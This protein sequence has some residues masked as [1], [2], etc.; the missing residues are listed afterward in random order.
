MRRRRITAVSNLQA[1]NIALATGFVVTCGDAVQAISDKWHVPDSTVGFEHIAL[2]ALLVSIGAKV[3]FDDHAA[4]FRGKVQ[5]FLSVDTTFIVISY[6]LIISSA[7]VITLFTTATWLLAS[8]LAVLCAWNAAVLIIDLCGRKPPSPPAS[9]APGLRGWAGCLHV[10][11]VQ[12]ERT[13]AWFFLDLVSAGALFAAVATDAPRSSILV[14]AATF[15]AAD[16]A[17]SGSYKQ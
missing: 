17:F 16:I 3:A 15:L 1:L 11:H 9:A 6:S 14:L 7:A 13:C 5:P 12:L 10:R 8:Y 2:L 4:L